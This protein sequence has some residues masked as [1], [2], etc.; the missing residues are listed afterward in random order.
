MDEILSDHYLILLFMQWAKR[1]IAS[2]NVLCWRQIQIFKARFDEDVASRDGAES[3]RNAWAIFSMFLDDGAPHE[4]SISS[5]MRVSIGYQIGV[6]QRCMFDKVEDRVYRV[7]SHD[8]Y[9]SFTMFVELLAEF[10]CGSAV[11]SQL[12]PGS[13]L[14]P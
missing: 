4:V 2:E 9:E 12:R 7:L 3:R 10:H 1:R 11:H 8:H 13:S 6:P 14:L 5:V